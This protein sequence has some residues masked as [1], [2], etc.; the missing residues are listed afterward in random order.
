[1]TGGLLDY[2]FEA[3]KVVSE[4]GLSFDDAMAIVHTAHAYEEQQYRDA[5]QEI[6]IE[7]DLWCRFWTAWQ[8]NWIAELR[9]EGERATRLATDLEFYSSEHL[10]IRP[11]AGG[12]TPFLF[13]PAQRELHRRIE[14]QKAKTGRVRLIVLKARQ[15]G[16]SALRRG[17][18]LQRHDST[19]GLAHADYCS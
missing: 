2:V 8:M 3:T 13:N 10:R 14:E 12:T 7:R 19:T 1:M 15:M 9:N 5:S 17:P 18:L 6:E 11:K 4:T 16:I